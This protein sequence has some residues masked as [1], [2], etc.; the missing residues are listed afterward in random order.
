MSKPPAQPRLYFSF[1]EYLSKEQRASFFSLPHAMQAAL[2]RE[3]IDHLERVLPVETASHGDGKTIATLDFAPVS[4]QEESPLQWASAELE[5]LHGLA[6]MSGFGVHGT[7]PPF[8]PQKEASF[9]VAEC[10]EEIKHVYVVEGKP[11]AAPVLNSRSFYSYW[12]HAERQLVVHVRDALATLP[13]ASRKL[14]WAQATITVT[15]ELCP[16][17]TAFFT[18]LAQHDRV[19]LHMRD[20]KGPRTFAPAQQENH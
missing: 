15:R 14:F 4:F 3:Y 16:D 12:C 13:Y 1:H 7:Q 8:I 20:P 11:G 10:C 9:R 19:C 6:A 17:C 18:T 2:V 5:R